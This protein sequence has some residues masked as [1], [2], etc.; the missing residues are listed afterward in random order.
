M[1]LAPVTY[2]KRIKGNCI[3]IR[4]VEI[5]PQ[6]STFYVSGVGVHNPDEPRVMPTTALTVWVNSLLDWQDQP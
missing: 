6:Q 3:S 1:V 4:V 5:L 2:R